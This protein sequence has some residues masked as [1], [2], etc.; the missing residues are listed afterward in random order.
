MRKYKLA[1]AMTLLSLGVRAEEPAFEGTVQNPTLIV[2][3]ESDVDYI[4]HVTR[5]TGEKYS[6]DLPAGVNHPDYYLLEG[7][8]EE[9]IRIKL[10]PKF[11][12][13]I[14][15]NYKL[16]LEA[17]TGTDSLAAY[18]EISNA[19]MLP[20]ESQESMINAEL[21]LKRAEE[22]TP[23]SELKYQIAINRAELLIAID[24]LETAADVIAK[25]TESSLNARE[26]ARAYQI[27][28]KVRYRQ[29]RITEAVKLGRKSVQNYQE[30]DRQPNTKYRG[31]H[32]QALAELCDAYTLL[33]DN[34]AKPCLRESLTLAEGYPA[35]VAFV[36]NNLGGYFSY[37]E[38]Y[39]QANHHFKLSASLFTEIGDYEK[40]ARSAYNVGYG[41]IQQGKYDLAKAAYFRGLELLG[42]IESPDTRAFILTSIG[43]L[44]L[45]TGN[46]DKAEIYLTRGSKLLA[47]RSEGRLYSAIQ[48]HLGTL[49][50]KIGKTQEALEHHIARLNYEQTLKSKNKNNL[51]L[52][53]LQVAMDQLELGRI[54][55]SKESTSIASSITENV[56]VRADANLQWA[57]ISYQEGDLERCR[58]Y[59]NLSLSAYESLGYIAPMIEIASLISE[60]YASDGDLSKS[61]EYAQSAVTYINRIMSRFEDVS[62]GQDFYSQAY[63]AHSNLVRLWIEK[64]QEHSRPEDLEKAFLAAE[65]SRAYKKSRLF[66]AGGLRPE[67]Q[68]RLVELNSGFLKSV[69]R[70]D[71]AAADSYR[72]K[73]DEVNAKLEQSN[74]GKL[75]Q[76]VRMDRVSEIQKRME[77]SAHYLAY[78]VGESQSYV[79][80]LTKDE[81]SFKALPGRRALEREISEVLKQVTSHSDR[82][83]DTIK[84]FSPNVIG[85]YLNESARPDLIFAMDGPL[86]YLPASLLHTGG[87]DARYRP[88]A[89]DYRV[90][91]A[92]RFPSGITSREGYQSLAVVTTELLENSATTTTPA[93]SD[94]IRNWAQELKPLPWAAREAEEI[95]TIFGTERTTIFSG[96]AA[97]IDNLRET[98]FAGADI[99]HFATHGYVSSY[100]SEVAG[101]VLAGKDGKG[102][103]TSWQEF[104]HLDIAARLVVL[105]GCETSL[106]RRLDGL[107]LQGL[108]RAFTNAGADEVI[109]T[110]WNVSDKSSRSLMLNFYTEISKGTLPAEA[111]RASQHKMLSSGRYRHPYFWAGYALHMETEIK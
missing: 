94:A 88:V 75:A 14:G 40:A 32:A 55:E 78:S 67:Y 54:Q 6:V 24:R 20:R 4:M 82:A 3:R 45:R 19:G 109:A 52:A 111:L 15:T 92:Q 57:R 26:R 1:L 29:G 96:S 62:I 59:A 10:E 72:I 25:L 91:Y 7:G 100:E 85:Q 64:Y 17:L 43:V 48:G 61:I 37:Q 104:E 68:T 101:L 110:L 21:A 90:S 107:G 71:L 51:A 47:N 22:K 60:S 97:T 66:N 41:Y 9:K 86:H 27:F 36:H 87:K 98:E 42:D 56:K 74:P 28:A 46:D 53:H 5:V 44:Y 50:R 63:S 30:I 11:G 81:L 58:L 12:K 34:S 103:F 23:E 8:D 73:L 49:K 31:E 39:D 38:D 106:G 93:D 77:K 105:N 18:Q 13:A 16:E 79:F 69:K 2:L 84:A 83:V 65:A 102:L 70:G 99:L 33:G 80:S 89:M 76:P 95:G 108:A 35:Q